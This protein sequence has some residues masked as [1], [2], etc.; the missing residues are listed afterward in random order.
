MFNKTYLKLTGLY[1]AVF[2][3]ISLFFS[4]SLYQI[5]IQQIQVELRWNGDRVGRMMLEQKLPQKI[6]DKYAYEIT[7]HYQDAKDGIISRLVLIN[8]F[9]LIGGGILSYLLAKWTLRPIEEAHKSLEQ[10][11]ADASHE[12]R[13]PLA[14]MQT[15]TEVALMN[16]KLNIKEAKKQLNS[17]LEEIHKMSELTATMLSLARFN[18]DGNFEFS[19]VNV[20]DLISGAVA[21]AQSEADSKKISIKTTINNQL[22]INITKESVQQALVI[23]IENAIKYSPESSEITMTLDKF[24]NTARISITDHGIGISEHDS[25]YIFNR[26]YRADSARDKNKVAGN[27]LGLSIAKNIVEKNKGSIKV[28]SKLGEGSTFVVSFPVTSG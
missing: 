11:T 28:V 10:F 8:I 25:K 4:I 3:M 22:N 16:P 23:L 7:D 1:L 15:E 14:A 24:K 27:G 26:F 21:L 2:M 17:N 9:V 6:R 12:L 13:T 19:I 5:S 20:Q 18:E